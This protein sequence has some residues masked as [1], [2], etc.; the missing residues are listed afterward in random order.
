LILFEFP[1]FHHP[2]SKIDHVFSFS[3]LMSLGF[4]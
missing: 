3:Q 1:V 2:N 4:W